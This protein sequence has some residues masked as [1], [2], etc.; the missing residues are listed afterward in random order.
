MSLNW[1]SLKGVERYLLTIGISPYYRK[2]VYHGELASF[3]KRTKN[4]DERT[5]SKH[6]HEE[7]DMFCMLNDLQA[8]IEQEK[9][10]EEG[11]LED[12]MLSNIRVDIE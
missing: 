10:T 6:F 11:C 9:K 3:N 8:P 12:E 2:W 4:F 5:S 1:N 7:D